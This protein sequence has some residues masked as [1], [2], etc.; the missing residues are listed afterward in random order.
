MSIKKAH[1]IELNNFFAD[2]IRIL[3]HLTQPVLIREHRLGW[4][5]FSTRSHSKTNENEA[6]ASKIRGL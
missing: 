4:L 5:I 6:S 2:Y 3:V 1:I